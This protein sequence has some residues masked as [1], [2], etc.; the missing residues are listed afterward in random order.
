MSGSLTLCS[1]LYIDTIPRKLND[2]DMRFMQ[3]LTKM[4][5]VIAL[6]LGSS[7]AV[8]QYGSQP[9]GGYGTTPPPYGG[10]QQQGFGTTPPA[11]GGQQQGYGTQQQRPAYGNPPYNRGGAPVPGQRGTFVPPSRISYKH[12]LGATSTIGIY[13]NVN[14]GSN[15]SLQL[16]YA[17]LVFGPIQ[18]GGALD[19]QNKND[20]KVSGTVVNFQ[21]S[22]TFNFLNVGRLNDAF[23]AR[24][25]MGPKTPEGSTKA[26]TEIGVMVGKR[27]TVTDRV[28]WQPEIGFSKLGDVATTTRLNILNLTIGF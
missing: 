12:E 1:I 4:T 8:A 2:F 20:G 27:F 11:Y 28:S 16:N 22:L 18:M 25:Y 17:Y 19:F 7:Q 23:Y 14:G 21:G 6:I 15:I 3:N 24:G 13:N 9:S 10:Q 5:Y 26:L